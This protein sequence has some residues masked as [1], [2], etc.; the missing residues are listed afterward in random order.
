MKLSF[1]SLKPSAKELQKDTHKADKVSHAEKITNE[2]IALFENA[3]VNRHNSE[4]RLI[5]SIMIKTAMQAMEKLSIL[6]VVIGA[7]LHDIGHLT[8]EIPNIQ[9]P[10]PDET[11]DYDTIGSY[12]LCTKYFSPHVCAI[13]ANQTQ[14]KRYL[15]ACD[16]I[17]RNGLSPQSQRTLL[18]QGGPMSIDEAAAFEKH[19]FFID[20]INV[21]KWHEVASCKQTTLLPITYFRKIVVDHLWYRTEAAM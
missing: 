12:Y 4:Q 13:A 5:A 19:P 21:C 6:P 9:F 14:A 3:E 10:A 1:P 18:F 15:T 11:V 17:F 2:I 16:S 8:I 20:I 7:L